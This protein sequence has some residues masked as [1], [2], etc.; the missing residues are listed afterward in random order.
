MAERMPGDVFHYPYLWAQ[1]HARGIDNPKDRT[2]CLLFSTTTASGETHLIILAISDQA[3]ENPSDAVA[4][5]EI[6][7]RRGGLN[8][9]RRAFV[10]TSQ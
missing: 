7:L 3:P 5:P 10:H 9:A 4:V 2:A 1:D 6:E 8:N